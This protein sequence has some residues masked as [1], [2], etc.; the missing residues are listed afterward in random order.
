MKQKGADGVNSNIRVMK[1]GLQGP[2]PV[3]L[4]I[5]NDSHKIPVT[6][7]RPPVIIYTRS[8]EVIHTRPQDFSKLVQ[9]LTGSTSS[10]DLQKSHR[11]KMK[12]AVVEGRSSHS[13]VVLRPSSSLLDQTHQ[14]FSSQNLFSHQI[15]KLLPAES[16]NINDLV[17]TSSNI[18][19][20]NN[21]D[22]AASARDQECSNN[23][24]QQIMS[25]FGHHSPELTLNPSLSPNFFPI[26][27][28][29]HWILKSSDL[30]PSY[31][32]PMEYSSLFSNS[33]GTNAPFNNI[34]APPHVR[35]PTSNSKDF[36]PDPFHRFP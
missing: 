27:P 14:E 31:T 35:D 19:V 26:S 8:P 29:P 5:C 20:T 1:S 16:T 7:R 3:P 36:Y 9:R 17:K 2:R 13:Q 32:F 24:L 34:F 18:F 22:I 28:S 23:F 6:Q 15:N 30:S 21:P 11:S 10:N 33:P 25:P 12:A 4:K